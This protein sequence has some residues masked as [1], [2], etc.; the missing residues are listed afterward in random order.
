MTHH[1]PPPVRTDTT[2][3]FAHNTMKTRVPGLLEE[4]RRLNPDYPPSIDEALAHL[5]HALPA[6]APIPMLE[7]PAPDY[8]DWAG[9]YAPH[10]GET[11]LGS[12][13]FFTEVYLYRLV[14]QAVRWWE[15]GRDPFAPRKEK[16]LKDASLWDFLDEM[17]DESDLGKLLHYT[18]WGNR[19]DLS[20]VAASAHGKFGD[21]DD[22]LADDTEITLA[23]LAAC[24][25][26]VHI[27][28]D[29]SGTELASDLALMNALLEGGVQQV[30]Y[31][32][33]MHPF[34]VSDSIVADVLNFLAWAERKSAKGGALVG[35]LRR[36]LDAGR[37]RLMPDLY[38]NSPLFLWELP[39]R[40]VKTFAAAEI[41]ILK[42]DLNYRRAVGDAIWPPETPFAQAVEY[43]PA[44][45]LALR[46]MKS[47]T[48]LGL[49]A[50]HAQQLD[51][52]DPQWRVNGKRG[53]IQFALRSDVKSGKA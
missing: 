22:L 46:T 35:R 51:K 1:T 37:L 42:G 13:W 17:L 20:L 31:H 47:D 25:R 48:A 12:T 34:F 32:V 6:N 21:A 18:L 10:Q 28:A 44:P 53:V 11:W 43:F 52:L 9:Y 27:V 41:V 19:H 2:N 16:E 3:L 5:A 36:M 45:L 40:L 4:T 23:H 38:W 14:I 33:K 30:F 50:G 26:S 49:A 24:R 15:N 29:N 8:D 7:L 39:P